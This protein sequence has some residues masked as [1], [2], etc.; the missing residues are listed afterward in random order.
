MIPKMIFN[1]RNPSPTTMLVE[2]IFHIEHISYGRKTGF[3]WWCIFE[4]INYL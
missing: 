1:N 4:F 3:M 2:H